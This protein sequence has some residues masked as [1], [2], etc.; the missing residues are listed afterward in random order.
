[1][2]AVKQC[3]HCEGAGEYDVLGSRYTWPS[4]CPV[5]SGK[6]YIFTVVPSGL[7]RSTK[8]TEAHLE[9]ISDDF[10]REL[11][12]EEERLEW[13]EVL[14]SLVELDEDED[15]GDLEV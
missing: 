11:E 5:C 7:Y 10:L 13:E 3:Q 12:L 14:E 2:S 6:G 1:M 4:A 8:V 9:A 15:E